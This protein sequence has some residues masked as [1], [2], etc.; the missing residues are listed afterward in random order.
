MAEP[1]CYSLAAEIG[2]LLRH[3]RHLLTTV[4]SCTGGGVAAAVTA[5]AGSSEWFDR[6]FV[7]YS[8]DAKCE[9]VGVSAETISRFGAVSE[10]TAL[11]MATGGLRHSNATISIA[12]TGIAGPDGGSQEKPVGTVWFAWALR[13][14]PSHCETRHF[15]GNRSAV[16]DQSICHALAG[17]RELPNLTSE[18]IERG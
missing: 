16:R 4:E 12:L 7:T 2:A 5:I 13:T 3:S 15:R 1:N 17:V 8:N 10:Q 18:S 11:A 14:G 9:M 6:G